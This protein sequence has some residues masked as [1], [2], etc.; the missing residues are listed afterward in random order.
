MLRKTLNPLTEKQAKDI[1]TE[2]KIYVTNMLVS[3]K[4]KFKWLHFFKHFKLQRVLKDTGKQLQD[5]KNGHSCI[6]WYKLSRK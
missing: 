2:E 4:C 5:I 3:K 6:N 1:F